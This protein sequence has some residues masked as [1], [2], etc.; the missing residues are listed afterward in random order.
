MILCEYVCHICGEKFDDM[1]PY[2]ARDFSTCPKCQCLSEKVL[3]PVNFTFGWKLSD[4]SH[5]IR[6]HKDEFVRDI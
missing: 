3:S 1:M 4:E 6:G 2:G 5:N